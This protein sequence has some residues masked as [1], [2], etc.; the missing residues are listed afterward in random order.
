MQNLSPS[1]CILGKNE[2]RTAYYKLE[3]TV[4]I[5][6]VID[7]MAAELIRRVTNLGYGVTCHSPT[8]AS[9]TAS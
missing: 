9:Q 7:D 5:R 4:S 2:D 1:L 6:T 3:E 8:K